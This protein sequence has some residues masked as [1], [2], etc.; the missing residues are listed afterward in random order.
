M[1]AVRRPGWSLA[2]TT[3]AHESGHVAAAQVPGPV[4]SSMAVW[5][6]VA[7]AAGLPAPQVFSGFGRPPGQQVISVGKWLSDNRP[8][9]A[10]A[11]SEYGSKSQAELEAELWS[12]YSMTAAPRPPAKAFGDFLTGYLREHPA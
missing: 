12:E 2:D 4:M 6:P 1:G 10:A 8:A 7:R 11:V 5:G 3:V 9:V